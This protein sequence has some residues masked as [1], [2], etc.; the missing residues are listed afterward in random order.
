M[1]IYDRRWMGR[2]P[3]TEALPYLPFPAYKNEVRL[4][5]GWDVDPGGDGGGAGVIV[6]AH[7][8]GQVGVYSAASG[9]RVGF[10]P[11]GAG[12]REPVRCLRVGRV[13]G[14]EMPSVLVGAGGGVLK[15]S[16]GAGEGEE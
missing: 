14:E 11:L 15:F 1:A 10:L 2:C 13:R 5:I 6:A 9:R 12:E 8:D 7:D 4:R 3:R 16:C